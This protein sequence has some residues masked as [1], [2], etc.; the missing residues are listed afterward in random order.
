MAPAASLPPGQACH[1]CNRGRQRR[2]QCQYPRHCQT[3]NM[4]EKPSR[5]IKNL[6]ENNK[7]ATHTR[8][9]RGMLGKR[10]RSQALAGTDTAGGTVRGRALEKSPSPT[11]LSLLLY[12]KD[13]CTTSQL[14]RGFRHTARVKPSLCSPQGT[15]GLWE[16]PAAPGGLWETPATPAAASA[17]LQLHCSASPWDARMPTASPQL[18]WWEFTNCGRTHS[19]RIETLGQQPHVRETGTW[20]GQGSGQH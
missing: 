14:C 13:E 9:Q 5:E 20:A 1:A 11:V 16:M 4:R 8:K 7:T 10:S 2:P 6:K 15:G 17:V 3:P 12:R 19:W 18:Q